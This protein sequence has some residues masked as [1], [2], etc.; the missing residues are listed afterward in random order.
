MRLDILAPAEADVVRIYVLYLAIVAGFVFAYGLTMAPAGPPV[1]LRLQVSGGEAVATIFLYVAISTVVLAIKRIYGL[2]DVEQ[3]GDFYRNIATMPVLMQQIFVTL[4]AMLLCTKIAVVGVLGARSMLFSPAMLLLI[5]FELLV[6]LDLAGNRREIVALF[7]ILMI[8]VDL[9]SRPIR[10]TIALSL[11]AAAIAAF[12]LAGVARAQLGAGTAPGLADAISTSSEFTSVFTTA[13]DVGQLK[14]SGMEGD[15]RAI[16]LLG[17]LLAVIPRQFLPFDKTT[18]ADWY[19]ETLYPEAADAGQGF[20]F[21]VAAEAATGWGW[22]EALARGATI[23][24]FLAFVARRLRKGTLG[25]GWFIVAL[26][27][28]IGSYDF[29]RVGVLWFLPFLTTRFL[30]LYLLLWGLA[31][32][33]DRLAQ[34]PG[35]PARPSHVRRAAP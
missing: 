18:P 31:R 20:A 2:L 24:L 28:V 10:M 5:A 1:R 14:G 34:A 33:F 9:M 27:L 22:A 13:H 26:L 32:L 17:P 4:S 21:G 29:F 7:L 19:M 12:L 35:L 15:L 11:G 16:V 23:G 3:H 8:A 6:N 25:L 30:P